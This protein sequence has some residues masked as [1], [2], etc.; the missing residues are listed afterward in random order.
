MPQQISDLFRRI[1]PIFDSTVGDLVITLGVLA[2]AFGLALIVAALLRRLLSRLGLKEG[3]A[4]RLR[5]AVRVVLGPERVAQLDVDRLASRILFWGLLILVGAGIASVV[6]FGSVGGASG[7]LLDRVMGLL[8]QLGRALLLLVTAWILAAILRRAVRAA[9]DL[10]GVDDRLEESGGEARPSRL[11][12]TVPEAVYWI[13]LLLFLPSVLRALDLE[14]VLLPIET[15]VDEVVRFLPNVLGAVIILLAGWLLARIVKA[16][17]VNLMTVLGLDR[18]A[19]RLGIRR[20]LG[21]RS[22]SAVVGGLAYLLV[23]FPVILTGL[24]RLGLAVITGPATDMLGRVL[25][26]V[27]LVLVAAG[28]LLT[29][30]IVGRVISNLVRDLLRESGFDHL[31]TR[32]GLT[33]A[34]PPEELS[35]SNIV[36]VLLLALIMVVAA[37]EAAS[38]VGFTNAAGLLTRLLEFAGHVFLGLVFLAVGV[39]ASSFAARAIAAS[40]IPQARLLGLL[41]RIGILLFTTAVGLEQM[42]IANEIIELAFGIVLGAVA[43]AFAVAFGLGGRDAAARQIERWRAQ[44]DDEPPPASEPPPRPP[45]SGSGSAAGGSG[46]GAENASSGETAPAPAPGAS[47]PAG[48]SGTTAQS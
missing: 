43:V 46:P 21:S 39:A 26:A 27:P 48:V 42:G 13:V 15:I 2:S 10:A 16:M 8:A 31:L 11:S 14:G 35:A 6:P 1:P 30:Y 20:V 7:E 23:L 41:A 38:L 40:S 24:D 33:G 19:E 3:V 22:P 47:A 25:G 32:L 18:A 9:L 45:P 34:A 4:A 29:A 44:L 37:I 36:R 12:H 5:A 17:V 28:L